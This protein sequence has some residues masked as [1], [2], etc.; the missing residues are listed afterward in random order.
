MYALHNMA[1]LLQDFTTQPTFLYPPPQCQ[2]LIQVQQHKSNQCFRSHTSVD[3]GFLS[4]NQDFSIR[5]R[6]QTQIPGCMII[7]CINCTRQIYNKRYSAIH[8]ANRTLANYKQNGL[9][10]ELCLNF[11]WQYYLEKTRHYNCNP[12]T[13]IFYQ[14]N[15]IPKFNQHQMYQKQSDHLISL[16]NMPN[17]SNS[18]YKYREICMHINHTSCES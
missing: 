15:I 5:I 18:E 12:Q 3:V 7:I 8:I 10:S 11:E 6:C 16:I 2:H 14:C 9:I 17:P 1:Q 13:R 4:A